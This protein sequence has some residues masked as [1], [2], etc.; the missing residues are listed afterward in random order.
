[1]LQLLPATVWLPQLLLALSAAVE[2]QLLCLHCRWPGTAS[3]LIR[4]A[5]AP[6]W[7]FFPLDAAHD[8]RRLCLSLRC[9]LRL[10]RLHNWVH[11]L[12]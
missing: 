5:L 8:G 9:P 10:L 2:P 4:V 1:M 7:R 11:L 6:V 3:L 12:L